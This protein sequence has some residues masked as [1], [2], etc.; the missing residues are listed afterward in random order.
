MT[1]LCLDTPALEYLRKMFRTIQQRNKTQFGDTVA[2]S[3]RYHQIIKYQQT[4]TPFTVSFFD[5]TK[6]VSCQMLWSDL[7]KAVDFYDNKLKFERK[8]EVQTRYDTFLARMKSDGKS[9]YNHI[10]DNEMR[11]NLVDS[12][13]EINQY[14]ICRNKFPYDFGSHKHFLLWVHPECDEKTRKII[15]DKEKCYEFVSQISAKNKS[16]LGERFI[17]FRNAPV[18]KSVQTIEHFHVICY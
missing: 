6:R 1:N 15:F 5:G 12:F 8:D 2:H 10:I 18:N 7:S 17:I 14:T 4:S 9:I 3:H 16:V 13:G 11:I